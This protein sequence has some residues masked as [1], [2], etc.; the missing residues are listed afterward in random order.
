V[1]LE[2]RVMARLVGR[3]D[4]ALDERHGRGETLERER[5]AERAALDHPTRGSPSRDLLG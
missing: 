2:V 5:L 1:D 4:H 3:S